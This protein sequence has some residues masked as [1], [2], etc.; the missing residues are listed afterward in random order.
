MTL[1]VIS[2]LEFAVGSEI[3]Y[4]IN[5]MKFEYALNYGQNVKKS[6]YFSLQ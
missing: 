5:N 4:S 3:S 1:K 2:K 6:V